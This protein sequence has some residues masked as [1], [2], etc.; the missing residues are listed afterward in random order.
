MP[1]IGRSPVRIFRQETSCRDKYFRWSFSVPPAGVSVLIQMP[2][3]SIHICM[4]MPVT[5]DNDV[6]Y[7]S[8]REQ[9][10]LTQ[11][12]EHQSSGL[13]YGKYPF[14]IFLSFSKLEI[15]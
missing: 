2:T 5:N 3:S 9:S 14:F 10:F 11:F 1:R 7:A 13:V 4:Y 8:Q 15:D 12:V 6:E